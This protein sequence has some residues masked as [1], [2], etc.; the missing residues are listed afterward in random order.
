MQAA[1]GADQPRLPGFDTL[2]DDAPCGLVVTDLDGRLRRVN[3]TLCRW[4]GRERSELEGVLKLQDLLTMGGRIFHQ[5]HWAPLLQIQGSIAEVK[6]ELTHRDGRRIPMVLNALHRRHAQGDFHEVAL[7]IAEDRHKYEH[8]LLLARKRAEHLLAQEQEA[9][10]ALRV[11]NEERDRQRAVA[12]DRALFAEQMIGI[13]SHDLRNPLSVIRLSAHLIGMGQLSSNQLSA[14]GRLTQSVAR[15]SRLIVDLL[16]FTQARLGRGLQVNLA[17]IDLHAVVAECVEEL[18]LAFPDGRL[19]HVAIGSGRCVASSDRLAQMIGNLVANALAYGA[20]GQPVTLTSRIDDDT[21][22]LSVHNEGLPVASDLL[23]KLFEP[24]TR[25]THAGG[26]AGSVGLGL[27]IVREI[28]RAHRGE[29]A[30]ESSAEHGTE[31]RATLPR[32][33]TLAS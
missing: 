24:M 18:R 21:F 2:Y 30:A 23:P 27:F 3:A 15:A 5:T 33:H 13:V 19:E 12:E 14:L 7:F 10:R 17:P 32:E 22:S 20:P 6:L 28:V 31:F 29:I 11:A 4:I 1:G 9:Q 16:D 25:G 26:S 8:E